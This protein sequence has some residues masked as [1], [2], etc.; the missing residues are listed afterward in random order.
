[1]YSHLCVHKYS[2]KQYYVTVIFV[3]QILVKIFNIKHKF[4]VATDPIPPNKNSG[5]APGTTYRS[6]FQGSC[7]AYCPTT[8]AQQLP[9]YAA[10]NLTKVKILNIGVL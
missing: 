8:P 5:S 7:T 3:M 2:Y 9:I 10:Q 1:M 4:C 6:H